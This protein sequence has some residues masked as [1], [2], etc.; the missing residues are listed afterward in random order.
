MQNKITVSGLVD[1]YSKSFD[2]IGLSLKQSDGDAEKAAELRKTWRAISG[3]GTRMHSIAAALV[4]DT[5]TPLPDH[6]GDHCIDALKV[7]VAKIPREDMTVT[8]EVQIDMETRILH[9]GGRADLVMHI[10]THHRII[11][12][13]FGA[14]KE[15]SF[16]QMYPPFEKIG[17]ST[18]NNALLQI[19][20]Y[21][22]LLRSTFTHLHNNFD[23]TVHP[24]TC[25]NI[26]PD[27]ATT[28]IEEPQ[29]ATD[30]AAKMLGIFI[31][32]SDALQSG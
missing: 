3:R 29:W 31:A 15:V 13:K 25:Y 22:H 2:S 10:G 5:Y 7:L 17:A 24:G 23:D 16:G 18:L 1:S 4:N 28:R 9:I 21:G 30:A 32:E 19:A 6:A 27:G 12:W 20:L 26:A 8:T 14:I 11:D